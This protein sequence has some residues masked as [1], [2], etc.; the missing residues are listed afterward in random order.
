LREVGWLVTGDDPDPVPHLFV[1]MEE[2]MDGSGTWTVELSECRGRC[3]TAGNAPHRY[4]AEADA[5]AALAAIYANGLRSSSSSS[6]DRSTP[7][8]S[9]NRTG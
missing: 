4:S 9:S 2:A 8:R 1:R 6:S 3:G 5:R 7:E